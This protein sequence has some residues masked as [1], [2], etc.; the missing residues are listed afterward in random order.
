MTAMQ[1]RKGRRGEQELAGLLRDLLGA[2]I[3]RNLSQSR[4]G[5]C[6]LV[7]LP[8]WSLEVKRRAGH[9]RLE[10]WWAQCCRQAE[11]A[12]LRPALAYR[13]DRRP[14]RFVLPLRVVPGFENAPLELRIETGLV[15]FAALI[16]EL[17]GCSASIT[18]AP[19][20]EEPS[21]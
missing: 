5:G 19:S 18:M 10:T 16:R 15:E 13:L 20:I 6:D 1:Q 11:D 9:Q 12:G 2:D 14:W 21:C 7:G 4:D 3:V 17:C 8:G